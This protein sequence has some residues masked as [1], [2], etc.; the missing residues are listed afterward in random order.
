MAR[1]QVNLDGISVAVKKRKVLLDI[2]K[3][4]GQNPRIGLYKN[5]E[6]KAT[7]SD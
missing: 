1:I 2:L 5:S 4:D 3:L 6:P 7:V